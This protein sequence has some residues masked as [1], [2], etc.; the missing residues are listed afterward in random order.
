M[1][2]LGGCWTTWGTVTPSAIFTKSKQKQVRS[3]GAT[4][5][6]KKSKILL[7]CPVLNSSN[8]QILCSDGCFPWS[9]QHSSSNYKS[10]RSEGKR[11]DLNCQ[12]KKMKKRK[13]RCIMPR[14]TLWSD[15][16]FVL[17]MF[18]LYFLA[19]RVT[20]HSVGPYYKDIF[21]HTLTNY[22]CFWSLFLVFRF[23]KDTDKTFLLATSLAEQMCSYLKLFYW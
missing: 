12:K 22:I 14:M 18:L 2:K 7:L 10:Y 15:Y 21:N 23:W 17:W 8:L 5:N 19:S 13:D 11:V 3:K 6:L 1:A 16:L 9:L 20:S 4:H